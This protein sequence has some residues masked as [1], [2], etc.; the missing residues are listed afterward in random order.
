M[1]T[2]QIKLTNFQRGEI[3][4]AWK[5]EASVKKISEKLYYSQSIIYDVI[6][7]YVDNKIERPCENCEIVKTSYKWCEAC[8]IIQM[9]KLLSG[10]KKL[11]D[12]IERMIISN[13]HVDKIIIF[14][15]I[16]YNQFNDIKELY[17]GQF[18]T[19]YSTIWKDGPLHYDFRD[20]K[21]TRE[22]N[23]KVTLKFLYNSHNMI[24]EFLNKAKSYLK[25]END[26]NLK[27]YGISQ[28]PDTKDYIMVLQHE[29]SEKYEN[30]ED[31]WCKLYKL[32][33]FEAN[34]TT[35]NSGNETIDD[36]IQKMQLK[37]IKTTDIRFEWI[38]HNQFINI[39]E[40]GKSHFTTIYSAIWNNGPLH[41][42]FKSMKGTR[43]SN[44]NVTI[45]CLI[46]SYDMINEFLDKVKTCPFNRINGILGI[47]QNPFTKD[48]A[49]ILHGEYCEKCGQE[50][51]NIMYKWCKSCHV[52][53]L[54]TSFINWTSGNGKIDNFI[55]EMQLNVDYH[56]FN[57]SLFQWIPYNEFYDIK[58][59]ND[60]FYPT[61]SAIW[62]D[63]PL[64]FNFRDMNTV[65][66]RDLNERVTLKHFSDAQDMINEFHN[67]TNFINIYGISQNSNT[68]EYIM[69]FQDENCGECGKKYTKTSYKWC[70]SCQTNYLKM[71]FKNWTSGNK[72]IDDFI[73]EKQLRY[74]Y[75]FNS[76]LFQWIPYD[77]LHDIKEIG[78]SELDTVYSAILEIDLLH[79]SL[80]RKM[81]QKVVLKHVR[82]SQN[83]IDDFLKEVKSYSMNVI[84]LS[85]KEFKIY[86][87]S[88]DPSTKD[89]IMI[90]EDKYCEKCGK[91]YEEIAY[92]WCKSC[93]INNLKENFAN[94]TSENE[95]LDYYIQEMQFRIEHSLN[96]I[97]E[98]IPY[99]Q[100]YDI[101]KTG[102]SDLHKLK[103][104]MYMIDLS[105]DPDITELATWKDGPLNYNKAKKELMRNP[106][107][108]VALKYL[109]DLTKLTNEIKNYSVDK[110]DYKLKVYGISQNP[111]TK[112][113]ILV[114]QNEYCEICYERYIEENWCQTC[115][116]NYL[117]TNF[118]NWSS[119]NEVI[120]DFIQEAQV[121]SY[122]SETIIEW[123][124][125]DQF[126][127][128]KELSKDN[129]FTIYSAI[130]KNGPLCYKT[131]WI[132]ELNKAV[133]LKCM[134]NSQIMISEF[135][136]KVSKANLLKI[137][138]GI[139][140]NPD[141]NDYIMVLRDG[142][143]EKC[144]EEFTNLLYK[145]CKPCRINDL[146]L[147]L[148]WICENEKIDNFI[149]QMQL[150]FKYIFATPYSLFQWIPYNEFY[151]IKEIEKNELD[152]FDK[153]Y[154]AVFF[155]KQKENLL[156]YGYKEV[157]RRVTLKHLHNSQNM[158]DEF[159]NMVKTNI[160]DDIV[161]IRGISQNPD[162]KDYIMVLEERICKKCGAQFKYIC[163]LCQINDLKVNLTSKNNKY[164]DDFV[165][166]LQLK[167]NKSS[168]IIFER[169][170][171]NQF[172]NINKIGSD[173]N[174][175]IRATWR[176][177][178]LYY[179]N[180]T[181]K[182]MRNSYENVALKYLNITSQDITK[183]DEIMKYYNNNMN[184]C[185]LKVYGISQDL[186]TRN[187][188][189]IFQDGFC[190][191]CNEQYADIEYKWCKYCQISNLKED[192]TNWTSGN[193]QIDD[194]I[195]EIRLKINKSG[196]IIIEWIPYE[197]F[198]DIKEIGKGGF[199]R[200]Y[201][202][203]WAK[204]DKLVALKCLYNSQNI[205]NEFLNE[206][207]AYSIDSSLVSSNILRVYGISQNPNTKEYVIV[208]E[209]AGG[210]NFN[211]WMNKHYKYFEWGDKIDVLFSI[212]NGLREI[213]QKQMVHHDFHPGN[214]L[215]RDNIS[216]YV[217]SISGICISDMGLCGE[218]GST[219]ESKLFGV[220]PY[221][222]PEVLRG[223][224]YTQAADIYSFGMIM[225]FIATGRQPFSNCAHDH[226][227]VLDICKDEIRPEINELGMPKCYV[228]LMKKCWDTN[229][230]NRP[231]VNEI[232]EIIKMFKEQKYY[233]IE[234]QFKE[235]EKYR[236]AEECRKANLPLDDESNRLITHSQAIY[237]SRLLSTE[238]FDDLA[239]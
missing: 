106:N 105:I 99:N 156:H 139:T 21:G 228:D 82:D 107:E 118:E 29:Y 208:L 52:N 221:M 58:E 68:K 220:M 113:Y 61:Y 186:V 80:N 213:H 117:R 2:K 83:M 56:V 235:A 215:F 75:I 174:T 152:N 159:L 78:K 127:D 233:E 178:P 205:T 211:D 212:I 85:I 91:E 203:R 187:C 9:E 101:K 185:N 47:S 137:I 181:G 103:L 222:A 48:Y 164:V 145:W 119:K 18:V 8:Q 201:S 102:K 67:K 217:Y 169:I 53:D 24:N 158:I 74:G 116:P 86:G 100:F 26:L 90:L 231:D 125:Y 223:E 13:V 234:M 64:Y 7:A 224:P 19:I 239:I 157:L 1:S 173:L 192:F 12:F 210:G 218:I 87:I 123:V 189:I 114:L 122:T 17:K 238:S 95:Q 120:D 225:Y 66:I 219:K 38:P 144:G 146:K 204:T 55:Q 175:V 226:F 44:K 142:Y 138:C 165:H 162:T 188:F 190:E 140:Q 197:Q 88:Q 115:Q 149:Q 170:P 133:I 104:D 76:L 50:Y 110:S 10:N 32:N 77:N 227:L 180:N 3:I 183:P 112:D 151:N 229:P 62:E 65:A 214:I 94:W 182:F 135:L 141:T 36:F 97:V 39:K 69:V 148:K 57:S 98:W 16:P 34:F 232:Q 143:C 96:V 108:K 41:Y 154:S 46:N 200:V 70:D 4:G 72:R 202:A 177:G 199:A 73:Q 59:K 37:I 132:R 128:I 206:I 184:Y 155:E 35:Y 150:E 20:M 93:Q 194:L 207:R 28:N 136:Y 121:K 33:Y 111:V 236:E 23:K 134:H 130:W 209:Y 49:M 81:V 160:I 216:S 196:D 171:Y 89:Y 109:K 126:D 31:E 6:A 191:K 42:D 147:N 14:E 51:T 131:E 153:I 237:T 179:D 5:C 198:S 25:N 11:D 40:V 168:D 45:K 63:G 79:Y 60:D 163:D 15:W 195:Q 230:D 193:K 167:I 71:N 30:I 172:Y 124:P 161:K 54:K 176:N 27:L 92:E 43:E 22:S 84:D 129:S 166:E